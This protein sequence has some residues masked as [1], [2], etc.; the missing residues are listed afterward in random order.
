MLHLCYIY[1]I[2]FIRLLKDNPS[3]VQHWSRLMWDRVPSD[4]RL[5]ALDE[6]EL[7]VFDQAEHRMY[8]IKQLKAI[9]H[10]NEHIKKMSFF[11]WLNSIGDIIKIQRNLRQAFL[12]K[13]KG[14]VVFW[15]DW[16]I[17]Q[18]RKRKR[19]ILADV[20]GCYTIKGRIF[21]RW[22]LM[23]YT[24]K[25][26]IFYAGKFDKQI[27]YIKQGFFRLKES[28]RLYSLRQ[29]LCR[30]CN[31]VAWVLNHELAD[32]YWYHTHGKKNFQGKACMCVYVYVGIYVCV[33]V[34]GHRCMCGYVGYIYVWICGDICM[35]GYIC[36][37]ICGY[38]YVWIFVWG[39]MYVLY[40]I[41]IYA[42]Y[43]YATLRILYS[44]YSMLC[45]L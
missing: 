9:K 8:L 6:I 32:H 18:R 28:K 22:R 44:S 24:H 37:W 10:N 16:T 4:F 36:V 1:R 42:I 27:K 23:V 31:N 14:M 11:Q 30:W 43:L 29:Y 38:M 7:E 2:D 39:Y 13:A 40:V 12:R 19:R 26:I 34:C 33:Y 25:K 35:W 17:Q 41:V 3:L 20:I 21:Q 45:T 5:I 15:W